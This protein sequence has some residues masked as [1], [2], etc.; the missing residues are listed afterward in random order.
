MCLKTGGQ[1]GLSMVDN[2]W[3]SMPYSTSVSLQGPF[4]GCFI[5]LLQEELE[6]IWKFVECEKEQ[7]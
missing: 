7:D 4:L 5:L 6:H 1:R 2:S 3:G